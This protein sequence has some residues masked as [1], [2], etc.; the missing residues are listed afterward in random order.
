MVGPGKVSF[1]SEETS[2][3]VFIFKYF[4]CFGFAHWFF[5]GVGGGGWRG[6][7]FLHSPY[8]MVY[9][10]ACLAEKIYHTTFSCAVSL[11]LDPWCN[12]TDQGAAKAESVRCVAGL[13]MSKDYNTISRGT[14]SLAVF[15]YAST[16]YSHLYFL[17]RSL[18]P[19]WLPLFIAGHVVLQITY[20]S[21]A[22]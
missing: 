8:Y 7:M 19:A 22:R 1:N 3:L 2:I 21:Y 14:E 18:P 12:H 13:L 6:E 11:S 4:S 16:V 10:T 15:A 5:F 17:A 20:R 9:L